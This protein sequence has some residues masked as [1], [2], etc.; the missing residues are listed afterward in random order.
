[1]GGKARAKNPRTENQPKARNCRK[2]T[3]PKKNCNQKHF[4]IVHYSITMG[5]KKSKTSKTKQ[6]QA[7]TGRKLSKTFAKKLGISE[8]KPEDMM[9][10]RNSSAATSVNKKNKHARR[11]RTPM[12]DSKTMTAQRKATPGSNEEKKDFDSQ[13][14]SMNE[15][16][17][18]VT[19]KRNDIKNNNSKNASSTLASPLQLLQ[20]ATFCATDAEK[21]TSRLVQEALHQVSGLSG[22]GATAPTF[23]N[24]HTNQGRQEGQSS[25]A[26]AVAN[27]TERWTAE[28]DD[29]PEKAARENPWAILGTGD[30]D[31]DD[32]TGI[33]G[34]IQ[35]Q[36]PQPSPFQFA[37][38]TFSFGSSS[39]NNNNIAMTGEIDPD[40]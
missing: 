11:S 8:G 10:D 23:S 1:L 24:A 2:Y 28:A 4:E 16:E 26:M 37:P 40:L 14:A 31:D 5:K 29:S 17:R 21:S 9:V 33:H 6:K 32:D 7:A 35:Q 34:A 12:K 13:Q 30:D 15:R 18:F 36:I 27:S 19:W 3:K 39:N 25:L 38:P 22:I 20:P